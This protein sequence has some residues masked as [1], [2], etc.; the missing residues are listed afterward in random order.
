MLFQVAETEWVK[1]NITGK[2]ITLQLQL[3]SLKGTLTLNFP[4]APSDRVWYGFRSPPEMELALRP[5]FGGRSL[6]KYESTIA[7][8]MRHLENRLKQEFMKVLVYPNLDDLV[9]PGMDHVAYEIGE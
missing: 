2:N 3:H 9:L 5:C 7:S 1:K 8:V 4:P 6:G